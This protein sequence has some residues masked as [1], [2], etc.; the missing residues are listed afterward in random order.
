L[1]EGVFFRLALVRV[2]TR[3]DKYRRAVGH[4]GHK[5]PVAEWV[6]LEARQAEGCRG[7][8]KFGWEGVERVGYGRGILRA[9]VI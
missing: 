9:I 7:R 6:R 5:V 8:K 1:L 3:R 4:V 2:S